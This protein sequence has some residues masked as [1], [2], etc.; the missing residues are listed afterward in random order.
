[1]KKIYSAPTAQPIT[2]AVEGMLAASVPS[3]YHD[4]YSEADQ[5]SNKNTG[6]DSNQWA[7]QED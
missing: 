6:W 1:M 4:E 3:E 2:I 7:N 5:L